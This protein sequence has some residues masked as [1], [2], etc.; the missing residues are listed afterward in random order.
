MQKVNLTEKISRK[1][2]IKAKK[3]FTSFNSNK[4]MNDL[5]KIIKSSK[6]SAVLIDEVTK[7]VKHEINEQ[8]CRFFGDLLVPLVAHFIFTTSNF[9]SSKRYKWKRS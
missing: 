9:F 5:I 3:Q 6:D 7:K 4:H 1:E 8:E 2:A